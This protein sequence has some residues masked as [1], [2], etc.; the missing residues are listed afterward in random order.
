MPTNVINMS[1]MTEKDKMDAL[2]SL[3]AGTIL[4]IPGHEMIYLG[5]ENGLYYVINDS[6]TFRPSGDPDE[7]MR[8]RGIIINTLSSAFVSSGKT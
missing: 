6:G 4:I 2:D 1:E 3:P 5:K 7:A 8:S